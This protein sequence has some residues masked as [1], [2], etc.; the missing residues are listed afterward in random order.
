MQKYI[1]SWIIFKS[2]IKKMYLKCIHI[3]IDIKPDIP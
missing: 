1:T 3:S 2:V